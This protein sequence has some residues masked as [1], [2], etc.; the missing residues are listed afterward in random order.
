MDPNIEQADDALYEWLAG[1]DMDRLW[2][3][4][5]DQGLLGCLEPLGL[6]AGTF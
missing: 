4:R 6:A 3:G 2:P 5:V 1:G